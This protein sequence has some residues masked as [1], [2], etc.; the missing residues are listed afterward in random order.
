MTVQ[1]CKRL[2]QAETE[3]EMVAL[4]SVVLAKA[5]GNS[6]GGAVIE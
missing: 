4:V 3:R 1:R 6:Y 5:F 2:M